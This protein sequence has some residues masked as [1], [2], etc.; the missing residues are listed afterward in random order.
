M[1]PTS[2]QSSDR[3]SAKRALFWIALTLLLPCLLLGSLVLGVASYFHLSSDTR[4]LRN[5]LLQASGAEW[6]QQL[7]LNAGGL[8]FGAVRSALAFLQLDPEARA[9]VHAVR[10]AE[11][12]IYETTSDQD[13][14]DCVAMLDAADRA[15]NDRN[16][17]RVVGVLD[18]E[19]L[20]CVYLPAGLLSS[21]RM[22]CC[23]VVFDGRHMVVVQ[24]TANI[25][26]LLECLR[27]HYDLGGKLTSLAAH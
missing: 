23:V 6:R 22:K 4:A 16:W 18:G 8:T 10:S 13:R 25:K 20:V 7:C 15:L 11:V 26:P 2:A 5:G 24:A 3:S 21:R 1:N 19:N 9:A 12:G 17:E 14:P 27:N